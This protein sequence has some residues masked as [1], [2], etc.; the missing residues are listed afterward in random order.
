MNSVSRSAI[1]FIAA[2]VLAVGPLAE[3]A[4]IPPPVADWGNTF[5]MQTTGGFMNPLVLVGFNP[6][7]EPPADPELNLATPT[8]PVISQ[9]THTADMTILFAIGDLGM[10]LRISAP[11]EP[12]NGFFLFNVLDDSTGASLFEVVFDI[13]TDSGGVPAPGSWVGFN[14]QPEP[15]ADDLSSIGFAFSLTS[16]SIVSLSL[17][18]LDARENTL[19]FTEVGRVPEPA[20]MLLLTLGLGAL[21]IMRR[22]H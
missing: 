16:T 1:L 3:A 6:Q 15:P 13:R 21:G 8:R 14:P 4:V 18:I 5:A 22:R 12:R 2:A 9:E 20:S 7:P 17:T 10:P 11:G 19:S